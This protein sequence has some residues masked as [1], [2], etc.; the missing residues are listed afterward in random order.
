MRRAVTSLDMLQE[1]E[2]KLNM[3]TALRQAVESKFAVAT[4]AMERRVKEMEATQAA[5]EKAKKEAEELAFSLSLERE[6]TK[7]RD[8]L[9]GKIAEIAWGQSAEGGEAVAG[10]LLARLHTLAQF[11]TERQRKVPHTTFE[12]FHMASIASHTPSL[13]KSGEGKTIFA[14]ESLEI[15]TIPQEPSHSGHLS[16]YSTSFSLPGQ[17]ISYPHEGTPT[18]AKDYD[19]STTPS[20][21]F[22]PRKS[23]SSAPESPSKCPHC[24]ELTAELS[25]LRATLAMA[26][27]ASRAGSTVLN[28]RSTD[29]CQCTTT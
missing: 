8:E 22:H 3:E 4:A 28:A 5:A 23:L 7:E 25:R 26:P 12:T 14:C 9:V 29:A 16:L 15:V 27:R 18:P 20:T 2:E 17:G 10:E 19:T 24:E 6:K 1:T 11:W 21:P 13:P